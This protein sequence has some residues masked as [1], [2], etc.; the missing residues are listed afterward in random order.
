MAF[1][2]GDIIKAARKKKNLT[3]S[4]LAEGICKQATIS[5]IEKK[6]LS[7]N[8][9]ILQMICTRLGLSLNEVLVQSEETQMRDKLDDVEALYLAAKHEEAKQLLDRLDLSILSDHQLIQKAH[10]YQGVLDYLVNKNDGAPLFYLNQVIKETRENDIYHI[11]ANNSLGMVFEMK[12]EFDFAKDYYDKSIQ[13]AKAL[14]DVPLRFIRIF[15]NAA[16]FYSTVG[17]Y[18]K[19]VGLCDYGLMLGKKFHSTLQ[20]EY[21]LYEKSFNLMNLKDDSYQEYQLYARKVAEFND[22]YDFLDELNQ[23]QH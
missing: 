15:S 5:N 12:K 20:L 10:F 17:E 3:Q 2:R 6:N 11:L 4:Q 8:I 19:A 16:R 18:K 1:V 14:E 22:N 23:K 13:A 9:E 7:N 21:L